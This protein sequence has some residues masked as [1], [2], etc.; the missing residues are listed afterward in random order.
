MKTENEIEIS[1]K[2]IRFEGKCW[3]DDNG[4]RRRYIDPM[5]DE[6]FKLLFG[7][8]GN[9]DLLKDLLNMI[10]PGVDIVD[11]KYDN[12]EHHGLVQGDGKAI[13]DVYCED[14][15]GV[16]FLVEMQ[17]WSQRYFNKR[18]VYYSTFAIQDQAAKEKRHQIK[19]LGKDRWDYNYAPVYVV[20]FLSFDMKK[21]PCGLEKV[22]DDEYISLY[23]YKDVETEDELGDGTTLVFI[24]M[25]KFRKGLF[26]CTTQRERWMHMMKNMSSQLEI[27]EVFSDP[28][29]QEVYRKAEIAAL[30]EELKITYITHI[31]SRNDELNSRA[32]MIEDALAEG[33]AKG[34][35]LG[36]EEGREEGRKEGLDC[37]VRKMLAA[38]ISLDVISSAL[39]LTPD[40]MRRY[41]PEA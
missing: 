28:R 23:R 1:G 6:G 13:F 11:L 39:E 32:E 29:M 31:M 17:N 3:V 16:R 8:E 15:E 10:I 33:Y 14:R 26:D 19:T 40:Q 5:N 24:E 7:T 2:K 25:K 22:K 41:S 4:V 36:R 35:A 21:S 18:A 38:G 12:V 9:E 30:P 27:P 20:C 37:A 34:M